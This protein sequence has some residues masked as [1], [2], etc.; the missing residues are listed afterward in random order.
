MRPPE[1]D[2]PVRPKR[3]PKRRRDPTRDESLLIENMA[4]T[5]EGVARLDGKA[6]FV[7][8]TLSGE[9]VRVRGKSGV[10]IGEIGLA[11]TANLEDALRRQ[12]IDPEQSKRAFGEVLTPLGGGFFKLGG[13]DGDAQ[14]ALRCEVSE[15]VVVAQSIGIAPFGTEIE[16]MSERW[17]V[18]VRNVKNADGHALV[19]VVFIAVDADG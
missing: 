16:A 9:Q 14:D 13:V 18:E 5:G 2:E 3:R 4:L 6:V 15:G 12:G 11:Q 10:L 8:Q 19:H 7:P 1:V 17:F